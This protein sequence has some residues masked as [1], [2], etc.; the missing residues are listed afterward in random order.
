VAL[1]SEGTESNQ[2]A[3]PPKA[4]RSEAELKIREALEQWGR[5]RYP[6][7]RQCHELVVGRGNGRADLA[8]VMPADIAAVEIKSAF[9]STERLL[10]QAA[11]FLLASPVV[12]I[13]YDT[14]HS[15]DA[16]MMRYLLP[17][18]GLIRATRLKDGK[19][20]S[21]SAPD[22]DFTIGLE[23][24]AEPVRRDPHPRA[25]LSLCW[26]GELATE[27]QRRLVWQGKLNKLPGHA[28]LVGMMAG[29]LSAAEQMESV[30]R[31]LRSRNAFWRADPPINDGARVAPA[32]EAVLV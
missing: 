32:A 25:L 18:L 8:Y 16:A 22:R 4:Y 14:E 15:E 13:C 11:M 26:A 1:I 24:I 6:G 7:A 28:A 2:I 21:R 10:H 12:W 20:L 27:A 29:T 3:V 30:C 23:V 19:P 5:T 9:D 31:Q 17:W